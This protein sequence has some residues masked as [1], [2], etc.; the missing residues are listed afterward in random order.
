ME[1]TGFSDDRTISGIVVRVVY[2]NDN[3]GWAVFRIRNSRGTVDTIVGTVG[4]LHE[5][6]EVEACGEWVEDPRYGSQFKA[7][8]IVVKAPS[9]I[10]GLIRYLA[11]GAIR[12][13]GAERAA[14]IVEHFGSETEHILTN[15]PKRLTEIR[16]IGT[17][18]ASS[19]AVSW[20][21]ERVERTL[22]IHLFSLGLG[23]GFAGRIIRR[24]G[25]DAPDRI[26]S[27]PYLLAEEVDGIGFRTADTLASEIGIA[28][29]SP[30]R[31]K[32][33]VIYAMRKSLDEGHTF[34]PRD[35]IETRVRTMLDIDYDSVHDAVDDLIQESKLKTQKNAIFLP[36]L[37]GA[38]IM[39]A[40]R[41][42]RHAGHRD[43]LSPQPAETALLTGL[44]TEQKAAVFAAFEKGLV[45]VTGGPGTGKTT[46]IRHVC[47]IA[48]IRRLTI[49]LCA[50]TGR[51]AR[52]LQETTGRTAKTIHRLLEFDPETMTFARNESLPLECDILVVDETSMVDLP[53]MANLVA[54]LPDS[55]SV[56]LVGDVD[57]LPPVGPGA[58][59]REL[60]TSGAVPVVRLVHVYRQAL[61][62]LIIVNAHRVNRG[63]KPV[64]ESAGSRADFFWI[65][66][67]H[68]EELLQTLLTMVSERIPTS[69][70]VNPLRDIQVLVPMHRGILG[71][72][73]LNQQ[74]QNILNP[75]DRGLKSGDREFRIG[76]RVMQTKNDYQRMVF[77]GE[78]GW[79]TDCDTSRGSLTIAFQDQEIDYPSDEID[80]IT[81]SYASTVH[82]AQGSEFP[83]IVFVMHT[84]HYI[85]L[86]R[87]LLYTGI[88]R[89]KKL[90][91]LLGNDRAVNIAVKNDQI[92]ERY[93]SLGSRLVS[94]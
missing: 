16:G 15:D 83:V 85:M 63:L 92:D 22:M 42:K 56:L 86:R 69:L 11:S 10:N 82:K 9:S 40:D 75:T 74:L 18:T 2:H 1:I 53:L 77:N 36:D 73:N 60:I 54:A 34:L 89:G 13:I 48:S 57:Q 51:A 49:L 19:I 28:R 41:I 17:K 27:N 8:S 64:E 7:L 24:Y 31:I 70:G 46:L 5:G 72:R 35:E 14:R 80:K 52:R 32:A 23:R 58:V 94:R 93:C 79:I 81:L 90:V 37:L 91:I 68:P 50:P 25:S 47:R 29:D 12:G 59:L 44:D 62:S 26:R 71:T 78:Q 6:E 39:I 20:K 67:N 21:K 3:T 30:F 66:R 33:G 65:K 4:R 87:N 43:S 45:V 55:C 84:Q 61:N 88:T 38:E 76:D